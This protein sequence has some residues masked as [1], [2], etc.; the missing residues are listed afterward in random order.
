MTSLIK[1]Y[2]N[3]NADLLS[4][5]QLTTRRKFL[6]GFALTAGSV[7]LAGCGGG[8]DSSSPSSV[9]N[10]AVNAAITPPT[11]IV[12]ASSF[13]VKAD[14]S[15][16]DRVAL[17]NAINGSVGKILLISGQVR[18]DVTGVALLTNSYIRFASGASIKLLPHNSTF[19]QVMRIWDVQNV[20]VQNAYI[21]GSKELNSA[22]PSANS[23]GGGMGIS[24]C[25]ASNVTLTSP[26]TIDTWGDG[27]YIA[28]SYKAAATV[29]SNVTVSNHISNGVRRNGATIIS[30]SGITFTNPVWENCS[31]T[32]PSAGLDIEPNSNADVLSNIKIVTPTTT[33]CHFGINI[34]LANLPGAVAKNVSIAIS[35]HTDNAANDAGFYVSGLTLNGHTVSGL[36]TSASPTFVGSKSGYRLSAWDMSGPSVE[37]TNVTTRA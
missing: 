26:T 10:A 37:V 19:Y 25:G 9:A 12:N 33:N 16:N 1:R 29:T 2:A 13:G 23:G 35:N 18:I 34:Y 28:N 5:D 30:G 22:A 14:G 24:I 17:Q 31:G 7:M 32:M 4:L 21:D 11:T 20:T 15:T 6:T 3:A 27:I 36:I 8:G